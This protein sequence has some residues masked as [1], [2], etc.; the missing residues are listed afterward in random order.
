MLRHLASLTAESS[1]VY[2]RRWSFECTRLVSY[3][4]T[5]CRR[6]AL[7]LLAA[8]DGALSAQGWSL[9]TRRNVVEELFFFWQQQQLAAHRRAGAGTNFRLLPAA[10]QAF[11]PMRPGTLN[12]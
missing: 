4:T 7:L 5:K 6:G 11:E 9:M 3:Y 8:G 1:F 12:L 10:M 2:S